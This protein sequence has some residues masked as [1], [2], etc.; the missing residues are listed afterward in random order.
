[1][2]CKARNGD[3]MASIS[4]YKTKDGTRLWRYQLFIG[5]DP[6]TNK[7]KRI[8]KRGF[9]TKKEAEISAYRFQDNMQNMVL[10]DDLMLFKN[11]YLSWFEQYKNS[12]KE[13]TWIKTEDIFRLHILPIFG[14]LKINDI[15]PT[16]CQDAVNKWFKHGYVKYKMFMNNVSR[17]FKY[18]L[19][20]DICRSNPVVK[21][22][23]PVNKNKPATTMADNF[24]ELSELKHFFE[25]LQD[26][27]NNS[28]AYPFFRLLAFVGMRKGEALVLT[29]NDIDFTN[30]TISIDKTQSRGEHARLLIQ[31]P[32]TFNSIR[33]V[34]VD[35]KTLDIL[36]KWRIEQKKT[37]LIYGYNT[38]SPSQ[39]V[40]STM[41]NEMLQPSKP[42]QW[43]THTINRYDLKKITVHGLRHSY[44]TLAFEAGLS[45]KEV[46]SQLGHKSYSTTMDIYTS[47]TKKQKSK[48]ADKFSNY[49]NF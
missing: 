40:F 14:D 41:Q 34:H 20:M 29:Y 10:A 44:A 39:L 27:D 16:M 9:R 21:I 2:P 11:V 8:N 3:T 45:I 26:D 33:T 22:I 18:G 23:I 49:A 19:R 31:S 4:S 37:M 43:L 46:Q 24:Y 13:S 5:N 35:D 12:V 48:M 38:S 30:K 42:T 32:K 1:M 17:V 15:T 36:K 6:T 28:Q 7:Q 47:V 25:C